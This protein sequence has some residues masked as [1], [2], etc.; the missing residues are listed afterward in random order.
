MFPFI[1][2]LWFRAYPYCLKIR[3]EQGVKSLEHFY[4][5]G[6]FNILAKGFL[7]RPLG[8]K[9]NKGSLHAVELTRQLCGCSSTVAPNTKKHNNKKPNPINRIH[10]DTHETASVL[11][12]KTLG[13][14]GDRWNIQQ[15]G[16]HQT[17]TVWVK[18]SSDKKLNFWTSW[19]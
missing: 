16:Q 1:Y 11:R 6:L 8:H 14:D 17:G 5:I 3:Q 19:K 18:S 12:D 2:K 15:T 7:L 10:T 13:I 4:C 9:H